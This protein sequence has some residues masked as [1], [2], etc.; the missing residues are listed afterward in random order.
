[1]TT[2]STIVPRKD[3]K[4][5]E[6]EEWGDERVASYLAFE[7]V[8]GCDADFYVLERAYYSMRAYDFARF[9]AMFVA[10]GRN[11]NARNPDGDSMLTILRQHRHGAEFIEI[12]Q[13]AGAVQ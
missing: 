9:V 7:P 13:A 2:L 6:G 10:A 12:L 11:L 3:K 1:M 4:V 5:I 8:E